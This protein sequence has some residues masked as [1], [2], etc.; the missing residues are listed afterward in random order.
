MKD[1]E[2]KLEEIEVSHTL[3][4]VG[5]SDRKHWKEGRVFSSYTPSLPF[6]GLFFN[7][8]LTQGLQSKLFSFFEHVHELFMNMFKRC[9][10][11]WK[12]PN[13]R[14][15]NLNMFM[16]SSWTSWIIHEQFMNWG[17]PQEPCGAHFFSAAAANFF[18][19]FQQ[20]CPQGYLEDFWE[21]KVN[22]SEIRSHDFRNEN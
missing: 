14:N 20:P 5:E 18:F 6:G 16:N 21:K 10:R 8:K 11:V 12:Y 2:L 4:G 3:G 15:N 9:S 1:K 17:P 7:L 22:L 13:I 19:G